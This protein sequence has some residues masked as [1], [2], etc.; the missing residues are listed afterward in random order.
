MFQTRVTNTIK[1]FYQ[2]E[3]NYTKITKIKKKILKKITII[4]HV[5]FTLIINETENIAS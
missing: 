4:C 2:Q 3:L 1:F 5:E